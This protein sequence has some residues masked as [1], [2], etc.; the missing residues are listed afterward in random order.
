MF[1]CLFGG[2]FLRL[3]ARL[4]DC[5]LFV[6]VFVCSFVRLLVCLSVRSFVCSWA[7]SF[8]RSLDPALAFFRGLCGFIGPSL[9]PPVRLPWGIP[10]RAPHP[11]GSWTD[12]GALSHKICDGQAWAPPGGPK[13]HQL[14]SSVPQN[15][16]P[17]Y[18]YITSKYQRHNN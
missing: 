14:R 2:S 7:H 6:C 11:T 18:N 3:F 17:N 1:A 16:W 13:P 5:V 10:G 9:V 15:P 12:L 4:F 8:V